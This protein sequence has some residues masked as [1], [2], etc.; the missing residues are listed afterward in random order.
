M[1][2][3]PFPWERN[4]PP[5]LGWDIDVPAE[6]IPAM[7]ARSVA[8]NAALPALEYRD[9]ETG[10]AELGIAI[11]EVAAGLASLDHAK[12]ERIALYLPNVPAHPFCFYGALA[13]GLVVAHLSPLD[14]ERELAHKLHDS[15]ARTLVTTNLGAMLGMALKLLDA[16]HVERLIVADD[17]AFGEIPGMAHPPIPTGDPRVMTLD[18]LRARARNFCPGG[19]RFW[20]SKKLA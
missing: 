20:P 12:G 8:E 9:H 19:N 14:A 4:Y 5:G 16:G 11:G 3:R 13:A 18:A 7:M 10:F 15:G 17:A 6:T 2:T 1:S